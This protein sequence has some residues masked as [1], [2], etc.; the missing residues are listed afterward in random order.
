MKLLSLLFLMITS[1]SAYACGGGGEQA[2]FYLLVFL[3]V[4]FILIFL[5]VKKLIL[6]KS[7]R[8]YKAT[9]GIVLIALLFFSILYFKREGEL[10]LTKLVGKTMMKCDDEFKF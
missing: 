7:K 2:L 10:V 9:L 6:S 4:L 5:I 1:Q 8:N 3:V